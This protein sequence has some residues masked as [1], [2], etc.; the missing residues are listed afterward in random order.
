MTDL[1]PAAWA[2]PSLLPENETVRIFGKTKLGAV[3]VAALWTTSRSM[4]D[5]KPRSS[6]SPAELTALAQL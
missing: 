4:T 6:I 2:V 5:E 3:M 1:L